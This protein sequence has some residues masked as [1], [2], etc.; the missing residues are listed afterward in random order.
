MKKLLALVLALVMTL[1]LCVTS[2]AAFAGEEYDYDEAVEVMAAVGVF[3]GD[4]NGKFKGKAALT[5]EQAAKL[6]AYR[7]LG[8]KTAEALPA[9]KVFNDVEA[10][11]WSAKYVAYCADAGYLAGV[12][13]G[14]FDPAGKLTGYAFGTMLLCALGYDAALEGFTGANWQI[15]VATLMQSNNIAKSVDAAASATLTREA[16]AQYC[17]NAL[18]ANCVEY[19]GGTNIT[20]GGTTLTQGATRVPVIG[21]DN[22][23]TYGVAI[24][25]AQATVNGVTGRIIQLGEK[26]YEGKLVYTENGQEDDFGRAAGSWF[27]NKGASK[28]TNPA[29]TVASADLVVKSALEAATYTVTL[30]KDYNYGSESTETIQAI[31]RAVTGNDK[32]TY[33]YDNDGDYTINGDDGNA[34]EATE[35]TTNFQA[36]NIVEVYCTGVKVENVVV[37]SFVLGKIAKVDTTIA[38]ADAKLGT[39]AYITVAKPSDPATTAEYYDVYTGADDKDMLGGYDAATYVKGAYIAYAVNTAGDII[40]SYVVAPTTGKITSFKDNA[41]VYVDGN[42]IPMAGHGVIDGATASFGFTSDYDV[43]TTAEGYALFIDGVS[44]AALTDVYYVTGVYK[45]KAANG[46]TTYYAETVSMTGEVAQMKIEANEWQT[47]GAFSGKANTD[48]T[49]DNTAKGLYVITDD[50]QTHNSVTSKAGNGVMS[51]A[52]L[53]EN[54]TYAGYTVKAANQSLAADVTATSKYLTANGN[55]YYFSAD[56]QFVGVQSEN[57]ALKV[58]TA[59]GLMKADCDL[60]GLT[61]Y[62]IEKT[63]DTTK[64]ADYVIYV[65]TDLGTGAVAADTGKVLYVQSAASENAIV[66]TDGVVVTGVRFMSDN[67]TQ[68]VNVKKSA[69]SISTTVPA[70]FYTF[71][72]NAEGLY[73]LTALGTAS[74][75]GSAIDKNTNAYYANVSFNDIRANT[76]TFSSAF[77]DVSYAGAKV[78]DLRT[79]AA[80]AGDGNYDREIAS[81]SALNTASTKVPVN[82]ALVADVYVTN[83]EI[84][85]VA[86]K[87]FKSTLTTG[88]FS[89]EAATTDGVVDATMSG[90]DALTLTE[91]SANKKAVLTWTADDSNGSTI[92]AVSIANET[93]AKAALTNG[94]VVL[95]TVTAGGPVNLAVT[96]TAA[97]GTTTDTKT[98]AVTVANPG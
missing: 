87:G 96:I 98:I 40:E 48:N 9:I 21:A 24:D 86:V 42:K 85:F 54:A 33:D 78:I 90:Q 70:G 43:Y 84:T 49:F 4:E 95:T 38:A 6:G 47:G 61:A 25:D 50:I 30:T 3:K 31:L 28:D 69:G 51:A 20:I 53:G 65:A 1:S 58:K 7:D 75:G 18:K 39:T 62:I 76:V 13:D 91:N 2:N 83:G 37:K 73:E 45:T 36:G 59:S 93:C 77:D 74:V 11:R 5:R 89:A 10:T 82:T 56:T 63:A 16:A 94:K 44:T 41:Y 12:G 66:G 68:T 97:D 57:A 8:E 15:A 64:T 67:S 52:A 60:G 14:N 46:T 79:P 19:V 29:Y 80:I 35:I 22:D 26:L 71:E 27:Y 32:L 34:T 17:L 88:T 92:T 81:V 72:V 23:N 55:K